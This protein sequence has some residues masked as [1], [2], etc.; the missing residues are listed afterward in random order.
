MKTEISRT[1][2][3]NWNI[4]IVDDDPDSLEIAS[5][6]LRHYGASVYTAPNGRAALKIMEEVTPQFIICDLSMPEMSGWELLKHLATERSTA[7]IPII[8]LTAHAMR[9]DREKAIAQGFYNYLTK[10][11][12]ASSFIYELMSLLEDHPAL[13]EKLKAAKGE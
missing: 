3:S 8:A 13:A 9:G 5:T 6:V 1:I 2:L 10:P 11:L 4:L 12:T 7:E